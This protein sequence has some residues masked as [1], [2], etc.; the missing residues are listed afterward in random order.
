MYSPE[1]EYSI[2]SSKY[3]R[4]VRESKKTAGIERAWG[5][6]W[7][8]PIESGGS[9]QRRAVFQ[10]EMNL[11]DSKYILRDCEKMKEGLERGSVWNRIAHL[12]ADLPGH[13]LQPMSAGSVLCSPGG[14][15]RSFGRKANQGMR[16]RGACAPKH[17]FARKEVTWLHH[18]LAKSVMGCSYLEIKDK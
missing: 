16:S 12:R 10:Q 18:R 4:A 5:S 17:G 14:G 7:L 2:N 11:S 3:P 1:S 8:N 6:S 9:V 13:A 15:T